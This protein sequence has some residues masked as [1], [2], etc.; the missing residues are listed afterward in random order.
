M[1]ADPSTAATP[2]GENAPTPEPTPPRPSGRRPNPRL[3]QYK[4]TWYF[5][6][7]NTL[8][9]I[10]LG[11]ILM[12]VLIALYAL[13][14]PIPWNGLPECT[15]SNNQ[16]VTFSESGLPAGT[17]WSVTIGGT[18]LASTTS[19]VVYSL[20][21]GPDYTFAVGNVTGYHASPASGQFG[22]AG[23]PIN[24]KIV[25]AA[26]GAV[27]SG[28][29]TPGSAVG[30]PS[31]SVCTYP[32]GTPVPGPNCYQT[33]KNV[34]GVIAPTVSF[35]PLTLG[36]LPMG[37]LALQPDIPY[38]YNIYNGMLRGT[39]Y[40]LVISFAIVVV[41]AFVG[42]F[43]GAVSG[44]F[45]GAVDETIMR[46][47]DIFLSIPQLLFVI[48]VIAVVSASNPGG[49]FG[50]SE[51]DTRV[52][53]LITAFMIVWWPYYARI[54]RGQ[55]LVVREQKYVEAAR[56]SGAGKGR[57]VMKH[58]IPNSMYPV[59]IQMSLDVGAIPIL[60]GT[61]VFLGFTIWPTPYFP[62]WGTIA[63]FGTSDVIGQFLISCE[64][65]IC[66]IPWWQMVFP[67]LALF[68]FAI[69]VNFLS[70]GL[71]DALDP[72]LRR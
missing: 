56:A 18:T 43:L 41:G 39:D 6:R 71:R 46:L 45:G 19:D 24:E 57:I 44:F 14:Q 64:A 12:L 68:L 55:V 17:S 51:L 28:A 33:P 49:L 22:V 7:R 72:R 4:R 9:L 11:I 66:V 3:E 37:S 29:S 62:E 60:I 52:M 30:L 65:G 35:H 63:A 32:V 8:A 26:G 27:S 48:I 23:A 13:T 38:F 5:L 69:S 59:F 1:A 47:V 2:F 20:A 42:L 53:L 15:A 36:A 50:L 70:D 40:S 16:V 34:P 25:F 10:G 67:G 61:L 21:S 31:C 54:V 58:I